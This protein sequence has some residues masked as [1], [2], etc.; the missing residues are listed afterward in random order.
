MSLTGLLLL[1]PA[2][3]PGQLTCSC[4]Q[5]VV[6]AAVLGL[7]LLVVVAVRQ[8]LPSRVYLLDLHCFNPPERC[9]VAS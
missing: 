6:L 9:R 5:H 4:V 3:S 8:L 2:A 1:L 7:F